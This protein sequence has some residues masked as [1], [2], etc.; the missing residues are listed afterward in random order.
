[1]L[2]KLIAILIIGLIPFLSY[3]QPIFSSNFSPNTIGP[4][5]VTT[6]TYTINN[7]SS[8]SGTRN[9][10]FI[11]NLPAGMTIAN[12]AMVNS[13]SNDVTI[14][15]VSG[16]STIELSDGRIGIGD[17]I[18][19]SVNVTS[20]T[21]GT[22][23]N[24]TS[25]LTSDS[26]NSGTASADLTV[27]TDSPGFT[28]SFSPSSVN[29]GERSTLT[30]TIDNTLNSGNHFGISFTDNLPP[31]MVIASPSNATMSC[32]IG[33]LTAV[34][35]SNIVSF[36]DNTFSKIIST[37]ATCTISVDVIGQQAGKLDNL[38]GEFTSYNS[39]FQSKNSGKASASLEVLTPPK[40]FLQKKFTVNPVNPGG[41][42]NI[43]FTISNFDR[44]A[45]ATNVSFTL[46][47]STVLSGLTATGTPFSDICGSGS[48][49]TGTSL[50]TFT[51]GNIPPEGSCTF[52]VPVQIPLAASSGAYSST[53]SA[54]T[55][56]IDGSMF[57][58]NSASDILFVANLPTFTKSFLVNPIAA[59][60]T[61]SVEFSITN[62]S[63]S[64][65]LTDISFT[66]NLDNFISGTAIT[67]LPAAGSCGAGSLFFVTTVGG[68]QVFTMTGGNIPASQS[69]TFSV[70]FSIPVGQNPGV[71]TNT[72]SP[73]NGVVDGNSIS[74]TPA[75]DDLTILAVPKLFTSFTDDP[76]YAG[77]IVNL[78]FT[79]TYDE[80]ATGDATN[81][82]F[83]NDLNAVIPGLAAVGLPLTDICGTGA[84]ISG[85]TNLTFSGGTLSPGGSC[86][87][88]VPVQVP[89]GTLPGTYTNS[90]GTLS[91]T[92]GGISAT[93][94]TATDDLLIG[95]LSLSKEFIGGPV[96]PGGLATL[97]FTIEN[98]TAFDATGIFFTDNLGSVISG[99]VAEAPLPTAMC[100]SSSVVNGTSFLIFT[101]GEVNAN[102]TCTF[103]VPVRVPISATSG[104][105]TNITSNLAATLNGSNV[106][107][108][109]A[110]GDLVVN[111]NLIILSKTFTNDP[112]APGGNV[113]VE[114]TLTNLDPTNAINDIAF[115]DNFDAALT[116]LAATGL[117]LNDI[118]GTGSL[119]NGGGTLSFSSG[120]LAA[121]ASCTFSITLQTPLGTPFGTIVNSSTSSISGDVG[122]L[123]VV[124]DAASDDLVFQSLQFSKSFAGPVVAGG[125]TVLTYTIT[126][127]DPVN[128]I[129]DISFTDDLNAFINGAVAEDLPK[130]S[131]CGT[132][133]GVAGSSIITFARGELG[134]SQSCT[135]TVTVKTPC[136]TIPA[137]Y[138]ST[139]S[140][141]S[142]SSI[143]NAGTAS[144]NLT[145]TAAPVVSI[146]GS[147]NLTCTAL[148]VSRTAVGVGNYSWNTVPVQTT[149]VAN[150]TNPGTYTVTLTNPSTGCT[151]TASTVVSQDIVAPSLSING[152]V[153]LTCSVLTVSRTAVGA[154]NY[155]WN[156]VPVQT[157][158]EANF[159]TPGTYTVTLTN[160]TNG[161]TSTA[162]TVVSQDI[163]AP[164]L[165][166]NGAANLNCSVLT[167][168][169]TA[170]G[171]G[172]YSW[173]T[174]PIQTTA[175]A[176]F[177]TPGTYTVTL[178]NPSN[179]CSSTASTVV[180]QDIDAPSLSIS[181][182]A[183]LT[184]TALTVSRTAEG[185]GNYSWN[186][187]PVQTTAVANFTN[188]GTYTVTLTN[189]STGCSS[190]AS[191]V[192]SRDIVAPSLSINGAA[193]LTCT[194]LTVSRTAV[195][196]GEYSWNTVPV[197]T[198]AD[199]NFTTPGTYTVTLTNPTNGCTSTVSTVVTQDIV[200]PTLSISGAANLT[201]SVLTV[202]RTAEGVGN[203]SWNT[204]PVQTTAE[205]NF[206]N[207]GTYT[208]TLTN[209]SNG[210]TST[211]ST[212]VSQDIVAPSLSI[213][214]AA[215]LTCSV[216]TVSRTAEGVGE[217]SWNTLPV[218]TTAVA[219]FTTP[220]T[221][222]VTLTNPSNGC[223]STASTVVTQDIVAPSLSISGA[224][225]LTCT[226]LTVS[227]TAEGGGEYSW[228]TVPV[229][230]TAVANFT[231]PG[232]YTVTLTN[233]TNGCT[234]TASTVVSQ[235]IVAP[236]L[237]ISG[238]ASLTCT[239]LT[240]SRTAV[241]AG[242]YSW[243]TIPVQ[244]TV[245]ANFTSPGTYTVTL[246]NPTNGC[247]STASTVVSQDIVAPS[248]S[249]SGAANLTCSV[250]TVSRTAEGVGEYS[251]NTLP[252]QTTAV[253]NF[254]TPGTFT[255]TLT[256]PSNGCS[257]TASTVV[258][259]D[260]VAPSLSISGA[261][262]LTCT[263][264]TVSRTAEGVGN[265]SWNTV[266]V[267]TT[268]EANFTSPGI[269]TVTLTNPSNGC[270]STAS[271]VVTQDIVA[272]SLSISGAAN[273]T[274]TAL[275][276][277]RT[278]EGAGN[279][280][281][282]TV[283]VQTTAMANFT[284]PGT[285]TVT[286]TNP[287]NGCTS[288]A[289][290][291]IMQDIVAPIVDIIG[292]ENLTCTTSSVTRTASGGISYSWSNG[293]G[294]NAMAAITSA[295]TFTVTV[296]GANGCITTATTVVTQNSVPITIQNQPQGTSICQGNNAS[297][298]AIS[299]IEGVTYQ[300][301]VL[302]EGNYI[303]LANTDVYGGVN[304]SKLTLSFPTVAYTG[305]QYRCKVFK[306]ECSTYS[307]S[308]ALTVSVGAEAIS[309][310]HVSTISGVVNSQAV[311]YGIAI[312]K[313]LDGSR[314]DFKAGNSIEL[315]PGFEA[316]T[317]SVFS[318]KIQNAC[319]NT[320]VTSSGQG[321]SIPK[322]LI[323]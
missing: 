213:S 178:T 238:A 240:V 323:K 292:V 235:D 127:Q 174:D 95:G 28:K 62:S 310:V 204:D 316:Y 51:G 301:Q 55:A 257:S 309:V 298:Y 222:T 244:T 32:D 34:S 9:L 15:A 75:S 36:Q 210:C 172:N 43:E 30:F 180:S 197:Q 105:Y 265:Y 214:G 258:S 3:S 139:T 299:N 165:S 193:N 289:S 138:T 41:T 259:Q 85:T 173:N 234:S 229:Q 157:T 125:S 68:Q 255:V 17:V 313:N 81:I 199:A 195:G 208:V 38:S 275:T 2:K 248:L 144:A 118:C 164:S 116:G 63:S 209:P 262:N 186:T 263:A 319:Q 317:G 46:D 49:L 304:T 288:T 110:L 156:T 45:A 10:A 74:A 129:S 270:S 99:M 101:G 191:T 117:P 67:A 66:D 243:N 19:I 160:P 65:A 93:A 111:D 302:S 120:N 152:A 251:W 315:R 70:D 153:N 194:A 184:C 136:N 1:M 146:T 59:G 211:A 300:W 168:S 267:Q 88:S 124:G 86:T 69:C 72:T 182:A 137:E 13:S 79:I 273:L 126:N 22:H 23:T 216:L 103:D 190:T 71:F 187:V 230:T 155:S 6:L 175:E 201:C 250:L 307:N 279:Y 239:A 90:T 89:A 143:A 54:I 7:S 122:G 176:N 11:N 224:A 96:I 154:G 12:P 269:Y 272:P 282:N 58:G 228:N 266:P 198:T 57:T 21:A 274:C 254:T 217:Y 162:S 91:A 283:P 61:T 37:G 48:Q 305:N 281:W 202:S 241:G 84:S 142:T 35:G 177:T 293:L 78:E 212:V 277:S 231:N 80:F 147:D 203:Y 14:T 246:T 82:S 237:S 151:S 318:A 271:T 64:S 287:S 295:G 130:S 280:S 39:V 132:L 133:S 131:V 113:I 247:T 278:A 77:D 42:S 294:N 33:Q 135:F 286:L 148:S 167:V 306:G 20:S 192:I 163:V 16:T 161:C 320:S 188:P 311:S 106:V 140:Q 171:V 26:G 322:E 218:Q 18:T 56:N 220:G 181:G 107:L 290:T 196:A 119:V 215:N 150:F 76:V 100:G 200:A 185:V 115:T 83:I 170:V 31:G 236:S 134:P 189:P 29:L 284:N 87:F 141:I 256:N 25:D 112:V 321:S 312:N 104:T 264:L 219:N 285:Y 242:N 109:A 249:I 253:A 94:N 114:Y 149:S 92:V 121:G 73:L 221:F 47:L 24:T 5:S 226:A 53:T 276:V 169:R 128:T 60:G 102:S 233:P 206:T 166:I 50:L 232:T 179:G 296:T 52:S 98:T 205:A 145:V 183:N 261:A 297:F 268:A 260:I 207:P 27:Q 40:I 44:R 223:S 245:V 308:A 314:V 108:P 227:R 252:V 123:A 4:G 225:N 291:V 97:R 159:T 8:S 158:T 303:D